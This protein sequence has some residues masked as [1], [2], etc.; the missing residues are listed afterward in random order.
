VTSQ[1]LKQ[2]KSV[3]ASVILE[4]L[5]LLLAALENKLEREWPANLGRIQGA[6]ELFLLTLRTAVATYR[7]VRY[8]TADTPPDPASKARILHISSTSKPHYDGAATSAGVMSR[9]LMPA[10]E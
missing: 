3:Q 4:P 8:L 1:E 10:S 2:E 5:D 6:R 9:I 7:S